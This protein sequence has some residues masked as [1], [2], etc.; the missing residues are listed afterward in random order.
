[1]PGEGRPVRGQLPAVTGQP[2]SVNRRPLAV[3]GQ[4][5]SFNHQPPSVACWI[6]LF[7]GPKNSVAPGA[8]FS[9]LLRNVLATA[10]VGP[11]DGCGMPP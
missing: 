8:L 5:L 4:S 3:T 7:L 2:V 10:C 9:F 6:S 11:G 1:M